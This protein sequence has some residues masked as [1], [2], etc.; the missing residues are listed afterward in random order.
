MLLIDLYSRIMLCRYVY[1][2]I[3][4]SF[5]IE[6]K[7]KVHKARPIANYTEIAIKQLKR[8]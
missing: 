4:I 7:M 1:F 2:L 5:N 3:S 6:Q 8:R